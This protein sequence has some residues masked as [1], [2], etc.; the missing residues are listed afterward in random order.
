MIGHLNALR[1]LV[2]RMIAGWFGHLANWPLNDHSNGHLTNGH[3]NAHY[4]N[5]DAEEGGWG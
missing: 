1:R 3:V 5:N 2:I 4:S